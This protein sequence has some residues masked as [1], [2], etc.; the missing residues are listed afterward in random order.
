MLKK[1][2][3]IILTIF[4]IFILCLHVYAVSATSNLIINNQTIKLGETFTIVLSVHCSE[5][6]NGIADLTYD[7]D[8]NVLELVNSN[9]KDSNFINLSSDNTTIDLLCNSENKITSSDIYELTFKVKN[10]AKT[11]SKS[12]IS[13]SNFIIDSTEDTNSETDIDEQKIEL[14]IN[15][16]GIVFINPNTMPNNNPNGN[17]NIPIIISIGVA[18]I[19][20]MLIFITIKFKRK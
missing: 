13:I 5:G 3:F 8:S 11:N 19:I 14:T 16:D 7:Y 9:V 20:G 6:I 12:I 18:L 1:F 15:S 10:N 17:N 4:M 2:Y